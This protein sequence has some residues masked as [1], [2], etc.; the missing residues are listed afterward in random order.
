MDLQLNHQHVLITGA[1][2]GIGLACASGFLREGAR[3]SLV[4]RDAAN[5]QAAKAVLLREFADADSRINLFSANLQDAAQALDALERAEQAHGAVDVLVNSAGAARRTPPEEL[6]AQSWHDAMDAKYFTYV[7]M[8]DPVIKRMARRGRGAI[9][10]VIG[11]GGKVASPTHLPGGA[12]NA[13]LMLIS[14]GLASAY[15]PQ[16]VRVNAVNPGA[17]LTDRLQSGLEAEARLHQISVPEALQR[18]TARIPLGRL[19]QPEEVAN[20][21]LILASS[22]A[23]YV[24]GVILSMDGGMT[25]MVV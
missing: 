22:C 18:A 1:S 10:N 19:A 6:T 12:A 24:T 17:T 7:H 15:A 3:V 25:P 11:A 13:A 21:V 14:A 16:G 2:K 5:L 4:S 8:I 9:V 23:S 20:M